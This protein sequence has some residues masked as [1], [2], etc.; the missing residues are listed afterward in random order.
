MI[1]QLATTVYYVKDLDEAKE[2][3][4]NVFSIK[5][6]FDEPFY[7]GY[8]VGGYELGLLPGERPP[9]N[10][11]VSYWRVDNI[12]QAIETY[13]S[14]GAEAGES[15]EDV[16]EGVKVATIVDPFGNHFGIIE[17]AHFKIPVCEK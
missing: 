7:A 17:N 11:I 16:G 1:K 10:N 3:L 4:F 13:I 6:Y 14:R 15:I 9:S 5:P 12:Q 2:W 8:D